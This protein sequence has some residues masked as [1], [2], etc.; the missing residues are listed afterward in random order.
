MCLSRLEDSFRSMKKSGPEEAG[1]AEAV[2]W[3]YKEWLGG[4][5]SDKS[6]S[7]LYTEYHEVEKMTNSLAIKW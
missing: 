3:A 5:E 7:T 2:S 6:R 1:S 4:R